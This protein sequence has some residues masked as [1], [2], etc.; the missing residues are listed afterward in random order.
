ML[1]LCNIPSLSLFLTLLAGLGRSDLRAIATDSAGNTDECS[2]SVS[3]S[4]DEPPN[5][6][7]EDVH[8]TAK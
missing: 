2:F 8:V 5:M 7:C 3:V 4:D 1:S 6:E